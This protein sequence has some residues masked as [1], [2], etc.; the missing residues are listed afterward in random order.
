[1]ASGLPDGGQGKQDFE[2]GP[3]VNPFAK[4]FCCG[5]MPMGKAGGHMA[6]PEKQRA[7]QQ[8]EK[9]V[10]GEGVVICQGRQLVQALA[11]LAGLQP[12]L[13]TVKR[14]ALEFSLFNV[15]EECFIEMKFMGEM[16][17]RC[18]HLL[19]VG[20]KDYGQQELQDQQK[21]GNG[22]GQHVKGC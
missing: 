5:V 4:V 11:G 21:T 10:A 6:V 19:V 15:L 14:S 1:M 16:M 22:P 3:D 13:Q 7:P 8:G 9:E 18:K 20:M 17:Q 2:F 12:L